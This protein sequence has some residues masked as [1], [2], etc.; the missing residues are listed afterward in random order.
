MLLLTG[1]ILKRDVGEVVSQNRPTEKLFY[2]GY[3]ERIFQKTITSLQN[4]KWK[5]VETSPCFILLNYPWLKLNRN[6][7]IEN[8]S[9]SINTATHPHWH[10]VQV[11]IVLDF[12]R[13]NL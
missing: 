3:V 7:D 11:R 13:R 8:L 4:E 12:K 6:P 1:I 9:L 5:T 10:F 2:I